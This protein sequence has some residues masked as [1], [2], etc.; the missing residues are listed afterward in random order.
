MSDERE[1]FFF[2][3]SN[4]QTFHGSDLYHTRP[5]GRVG[6]LNFLE[7]KVASERDLEENEQSLRLAQEKK[8][9]C[10]REEQHL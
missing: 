10:W 3:N 2:F 9:A 7:G 1:L 4:S 6:D 5:T 8:Q